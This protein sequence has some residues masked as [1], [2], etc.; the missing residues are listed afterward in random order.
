M[1]K[2]KL[3]LDGIEVQTFE[4]LPEAGRSRGT[5]LGHETLLECPSAVPHNCPSMVAQVDCPQSSYGTCLSC[6]NNL[7][8]MHADLPDQRRGVLGRFLIPGAPGPRAIPVA[9][10]SPMGEGK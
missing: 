3:D 9:G 2:L 5:V 4:L 7:R 6:G 1:E 8:G 10:G